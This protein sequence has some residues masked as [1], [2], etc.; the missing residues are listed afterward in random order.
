VALVR[1]NLMVDADALRA[2]ARERGTSESEAVRNAVAQALAWVDMGDALDELQRLG[3][4]SDRKRAEALYG[5]LP[6]ALDEDVEST[7]SH[8]PAS[9]RRRARRDPRARTVIDRNGRPVL[10]PS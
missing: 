10:P 9:R 5:P 3:A 4:F 6:A 2:L 7:P 8:A 1:K